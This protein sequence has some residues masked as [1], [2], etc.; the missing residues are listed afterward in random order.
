MVREKNISTFLPRKLEEGLPVAPDRKRAHESK[1]K[2]LYTIWIPDQDLEA[3]I[4]D[5]KII[6]RVLL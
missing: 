4:K 1:N 5:R 3:L 6:E 2:D